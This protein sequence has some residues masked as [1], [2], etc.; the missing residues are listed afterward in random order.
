MF[1]LFPIGTK[2]KLRSFP[3]ISVSLIILMII[4]FVITNAQVTKLNE[5]AVK[6]QR[7]LSPLIFKYV[8]KHEKS[9]EGL[10]LREKQIFLSKLYSDILEGKK[11]L[12]QDEIGIEI[13][14][15][16]KKI[17]DLRKKHP[18]IK[19]GFQPKHPNI[20]NAVT[21]SFIHG[22]I[23]HLL[24]NLYFFALF[25]IFVE[26]ML[27]KLKYGI[28]LILTSIS[29]AYF[30]GLMNPISGPLIGCSGIVFGIMAVFG[31]FFYNIEIQFVFI[32]FLFIRFWIKKFFAKAW[33]A[34]SI[35]VILEIFYMFTKSPHDQVAHSGHVG[36]AIIGIVIAGALRFTPLYKKVKTEYFHRVI[37][38]NPATILDDIDEFITNDE[39]VKALDQCNKGIALKSSYLPFYKAKI[40]IYEN[41]KD[42]VS[43]VLILKK[44]FNIA[45]DIDDI[46]VDDFVVA[47]TQYKFKVVESNAILQEAVEKMSNDEKY[48]QIIDWAPTFL[49]HI[50]KKETF[51]YKRI[52]INFIWAFIYKKEYDKALVILYKNMKYYKKDKLFYDGLLELPKEIFH[53]KFSE[54]S[55]A[56][57]EKLVRLEKLRLAKDKFEFKHLFEELSD[58]KDMSFTFEQLI[59]YTEQME[60]KKEYKKIFKVYQFIFT[61]YSTHP[62]IYIAYFRISQL[63]YYII[64]DIDKAKKYIGLAYNTCNDSKDHLKAIQ[65]FM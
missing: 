6:L 31:I 37:D 39:Y 46:W 10:R 49:K 18:Y 21:Y 23:L 47:F 22:G 63:F 2:N 55:H 60:P 44:Y 19:Y 5:D 1:F 51:Q 24:G 17:R 12:V 32:I 26:D 54:L 53:K 36:G 14:E 42:E 7:V 34:I 8:Y 13:E 59:Y 56:I 40:R 25:G 9:Y 38:E 4:T 29:S 50:E 3:V 20:V 62:L 45:K 41:M 33:Y 48:D 61:E 16:V 30:F 64:K 28:I 27:G 15:I 52:L 35:Y 58:I 43:K 65:E 11:K 57:I